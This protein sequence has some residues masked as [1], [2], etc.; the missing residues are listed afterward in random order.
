M[1]FAGRPSA[2][3]G[4][5][6]YG[7]VDHLT[8]SNRRL[9]IVSAIDFLAV[10]FACGY[11]STSRESGGNGRYRSVGALSA[12]TGDNDHRLKLSAFFTLQSPRGNLPIPADAGAKACR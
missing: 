10:G 5:L 1:D 6:T 8:A 7:L 4:P 9:A 2:I 11:R 12:P 3:A